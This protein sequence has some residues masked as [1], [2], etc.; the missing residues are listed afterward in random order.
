MFH[1][2]PQVHAQ[3]SG[4]WT[5]GVTGRSPID[6][7]QTV[8]FRL[9]A[10]GEFQGWLDRYR[11][12]LFVRC[13]EG[14]T[15]AFIRTGT[16]AAAARRGHTV[17]IRLDKRDAAAQRWSASNDRKA[18]FAPEPIALIRQIASAERMLVRFTPFNANPAVLDFDVRG[19]TPHLGLLART[20]HWPRAL[21]TAGLGTLV[22]LGHGTRRSA[23]SQAGS[24]VWPLPCS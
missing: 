15:D 6:D 1:P 14:T 19:L 7:S 17:E 5:G 16:P 24:G 9:G 12:T 4:S 2:V 13:L 11:A 3:S 8:V 21:D 23:W 20:C 10:D 18:L 22:G